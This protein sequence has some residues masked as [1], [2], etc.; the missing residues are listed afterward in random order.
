M[1]NR[2]TLPADR[3]E[4]MFIRQVIRQGK[5]VWEVWKGHPDRG[6][7]YLGCRDRQLEAET[8]WLETRYGGKYGIV[9]RDR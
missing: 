7:Q 2:D 3:Y 6:G 9:L 4:D 8:F 5:Y 1:R